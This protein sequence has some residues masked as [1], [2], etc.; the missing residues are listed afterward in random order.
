MAYITFNELKEI[1]PGILNSWIDEDDESWEWIFQEIEQKCYVGKKKK[2]NKK[3]VDIDALVKRL[4]DLNKE[5][6]EMHRGFI[7]TKNNVTQLGL[8]MKD[9]GAEIKHIREDCK[10]T[11]S[12]A[13]I[14]KQRTEIDYTKY[15]QPISYGLWSDCKKVIETCE[16]FGA[17]KEELEQLDLIMSKYIRNPAKTTE[18][19]E[20][21]T[22]CKHYCDDDFIKEPCIVCENY[23]CW[24]AK[25]E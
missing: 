15:K 10:A 5:V 21:C 19:V 24:E 17:T 13:E 9:M 12:M 7:D 2:K 23:N 8:S 20:S 25:D 14:A 11:K 16:R 6:E 1:L 4:Q 3:N 18:P 22:T